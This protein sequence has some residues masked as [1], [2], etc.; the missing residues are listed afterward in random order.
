MANIKQN[1]ISVF[2]LLMIAV[3]VGG[4]SQEDVLTSPYGTLH[5]SIGHTSLKNETRATPLQLGK[6]L[7][8]KFRLK[9]LRG[10]HQ[11]IVYDDKFV[12]EL[13]LR[14]GSYDI[15]ACSGE[16]VL[17]GK[18]C[19]YYEGMVTTA[20]E[21]NQ[22]T[23]VVIPCRVANALVSVAF[24]RNE[25]ERAR[26]DKYYKDYGLAVRVGEYSLTIGKDEVESSIYFPAGSSPKLLFFGT[27][28]E[29]EQLV[30][31]ELQS[32]SLP[33][34]FAAADHAIITLSLP[35]PESALNVDIT[36]VDMVTELLDETIPLSWLPIST[37][38]A[39]HHYDDKELLVGTDI[40]FSNSYP[41]MRWKAVVENSAAKEVRV[42]EGTGELLSSY[43]S[44][45]EWPYLPSGNYKAT[46]YIINDE[47]ANKIG[48]RDFIIG[49]PELQVSIGGYSSYTKYLEGDIDAANACERQTIYY[50]SV[51][52]NV[53]EELIG[54]YGCTFTYSYAGTTAPV[55]V[56]KN[57]YSVA[58][59]E[60]QAVS[61]TPYRLIGNAVFDGVSVSGYKD[62]YITGL[63]V[64]YTPPKENTG[65]YAG[66]DYV[67]FSDGEVKL[68]NRG[69]LL[70]HYNE[71]I[72][73]VGFAI[74]AN[75]LVAFDYDIM[76]H[77]ATEGTTLTVTLGEDVLLSKREE[78]GLANSSDYP[79]KGS[80]TTALSSDAVEM[81]CLNSYGGSLT[82]TY[83]YSLALKYGK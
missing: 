32:E 4:C 42:V 8:D 43:D 24:G 53:S 17:I 70:A 60:N 61:F 7:A 45:L 46:Y 18:D 5:L 74:H 72:H 38:T 13:K 37:A 1:I 75:T 21:E 57:S 20:I 28:R 12:G 33:V 19:P 49:K 36:K 71:S 66:S 40:V 39:M 68:G 81:K 54:K 16:N 27:L 79:H 14:I 56:G 73:N 52:L 22:S 67:T 47:S 23:S 63:P 30:S 11:N 6:P 55:P 26:F 51:A 35:D 58:A 65:W 82:C 77:P 29:G 10:G 34:S 31:C 41:G 59:I 64:S 62:F 76:I 15:I 83:I 44:S 25:E 78:G 69:S 48:S 3:W 80:S 50:P 9:I 2:M